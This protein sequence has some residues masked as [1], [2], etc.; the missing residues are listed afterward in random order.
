M[1]FDKRY[2]NASKKSSGRNL[3]FAQN[4]CIYVVQYD[5]EVVQHNLME[6]LSKTINK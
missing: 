6:F 4:A 3:Q 2:A 5:V 1:L